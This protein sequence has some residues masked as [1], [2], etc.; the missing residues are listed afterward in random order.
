VTVYIPVPNGKKAEDIV[1]TYAGTQRY[2]PCG[3]DTTNP[4][5]N[6]GCSQTVQ[7]FGLTPIL[8]DPAGEFDP[9]F[10]LP[11]GFE[12]THPRLVCQES[13]GSKPSLVPTP[14][15]ELYREMASHRSYIGSICGTRYLAEAPHVL[16][17]YRQA[18]VVIE[19]ICHE[20]FW[21][22]FWCKIDSS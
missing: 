22:A 18:Q 4:R 3:T 20:Y 16:A 10:V 21:V 12:A 6:W 11:S 2:K 1:V 7:H 17:K 5:V 9:A 15:D 19:Q 8:E 14:H 13:D